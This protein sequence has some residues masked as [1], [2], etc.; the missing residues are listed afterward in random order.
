MQPFKQLVERANYVICKLFVPDFYDTRQRKFQKVERF[1]SQSHKMS[2]IVEIPGIL[3]QK[4]NFVKI[5][6]N[7]LLPNHHHH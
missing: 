2:S 6:I 4:P 7:L 3:Q 5:R 1:V